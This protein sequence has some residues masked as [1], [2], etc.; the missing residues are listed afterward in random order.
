METDSRGLVS[1]DKTETMTVVDERH[2]AAIS[3]GHRARWLTGNGRKREGA[4]E[5]GWSWS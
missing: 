1:S 5:G 4:G 3:D 2:W